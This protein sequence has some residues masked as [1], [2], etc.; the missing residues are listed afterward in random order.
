MEKIYLAYILEVF[1]NRLTESSV[2]LKKGLIKQDADLR[3]KLSVKPD[4]D[5]SDI[6]SPEPKWEATIDFSRLDDDHQHLKEEVCHLFNLV[7]EVE[8][9]EDQED[10]VIIRDDF[11]NIQNFWQAILVM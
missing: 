11:V 7:D 3:V 4:F 5:E 8:V 10:I 2:D 6:L 9:P 1:A